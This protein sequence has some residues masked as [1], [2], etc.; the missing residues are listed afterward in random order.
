MWEK[1][2][3]KQ[4]KIQN[5]NNEQTKNTK[6]K[7][8]N[9]KKKACCVGKAPLLSPR[10]LEYQLIGTIKYVHYSSQKLL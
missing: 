10:L 4:K 7:N 8:N 5:K 3:K 2:G 1:K 6:Q 9:N